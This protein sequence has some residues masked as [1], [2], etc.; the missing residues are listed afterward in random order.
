MRIDGTFS[1]HERF[2]DDLEVIPSLAHTAGTAFYLWDSGEHR[3]LFTGDS[4]WVDHGIWRGV[5]LAES[6]RVAFLET[7]ALMRDL[8]F[9]VLAPW[10]AQAGQPILNIVTPEEKQRQIGALHARISN[11]DVGPNV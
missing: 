8:D 9:D 11:R 1:A 4:I 3:Y 6:D 7:L 2:G 10:P 5:I